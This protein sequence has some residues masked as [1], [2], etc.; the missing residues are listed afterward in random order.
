VLAS[1]QDPL[2]PRARPSETDFI[3]SGTTSSPIATP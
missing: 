1:R 3:A 2:D